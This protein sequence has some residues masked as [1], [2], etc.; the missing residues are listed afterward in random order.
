MD[1]VP[2]LRALLTET[3]E[4]FMLDTVAAGVAGIDATTARCRG[5]CGLVLLMLAALE[6]AIEALAANTVAQD[7]C[8][9]YQNTL[10][11]AVTAIA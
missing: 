4:D 7:F 3:T 10:G 9:F 11:E 2:T 1:L 6:T 8:A 5:R